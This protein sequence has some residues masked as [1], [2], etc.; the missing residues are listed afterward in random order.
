MNTMSYAD[1]DVVYKTE[2][3]GR[4]VTA[5][6][7]WRTNDNEGTACIRCLSWPFLGTHNRVNSLTNSADRSLYSIDRSRADCR[8]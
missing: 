6:V 2:A 8:Q 7:P 1:S 3:G 4:V 5:M